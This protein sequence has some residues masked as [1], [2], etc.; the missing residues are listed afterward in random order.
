MSLKDKVVL[1]CAVAG[2]HHGGQLYGG[3]PYT[4]H[5]K[6]VVDKV[7][8]LYGESSKL[9]LL[10]QIAW[11]HDIVEDTEVT[12]DDLS[13]YGFSSDVRFAVLAVSKI[14]GESISDY[15]DRVALN[16][17]A[18]KVKIADTMSNLEH[19]LRD[20]HVKRVMKYT[21]QIQELYKRK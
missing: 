2:L 11:L 5:L 16:K 3:R 4:Y 14:K 6:S 12:P 1:A 17:L 18:F 9:K 7:N 13:D 8:F 20:G 21:K 10:Q 19:S 15:Y